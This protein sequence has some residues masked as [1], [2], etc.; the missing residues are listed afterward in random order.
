[1]SDDA[2][3]A[4]V[5]LKEA[6]ANLAA[7]ELLPL[8]AG[9]VLAAIGYNQYFKQSASVLGVLLLA[10]GLILVGRS[11]VVINLTRI[12][13]FRGTCAACCFRIDGDLFWRDPAGFDVPV[14]QCAFPGVGLESRSAV[15]SDGEAGRSLV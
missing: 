15:G 3:T 13:G 9:A 11:G 7:V 10:V 8:V 14:V 1:M 5:P 4:P 12:L 6:L 2:V